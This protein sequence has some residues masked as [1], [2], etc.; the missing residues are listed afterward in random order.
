MQQKRYL[1]YENQRKE[2]IDIIKEIYN[3][4]IEKEEEDERK[5]EVKDLFFNKKTKNFSKDISSK[6]FIS[7]FNF[8]FKD[9]FLL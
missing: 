5:K 9:I 3:S 2:K 1:F 6:E 4:I 8:L 7:I